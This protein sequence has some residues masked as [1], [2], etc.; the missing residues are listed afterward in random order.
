MSAG[1][2]QQ[3]AAIQKLLLR[4]AT[5]VAMN[6]PLVLMPGETTESVNEVLITCLSII[7]RASRLDAVA[8]AARPISDHFAS[9]Q[10]LGDDST[11]DDFRANVQALMTAMAALTAYDT[12]EAD[13][14][15]VE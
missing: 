1:S 11:A 14:T 6:K 5:A 15:I 12:R 2:F 7:S 9:V 13:H 4:L 8:A 3:T 10:I